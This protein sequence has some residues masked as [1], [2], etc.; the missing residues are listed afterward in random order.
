MSISQ[1]II[2]QYNKDGFVNIPSFYDLKTEILP[3]QKDIYQL[4][5]ILIKQHKLDIH[6]EPFSS[7]T[8]DSGLDV[9][10]EN[11]RPVV[12][13]IYDAVKKIPSYV[14]LACSP[15]NEE[16]A[17]VLLKTE[18]IGFANQGYGIR[19]DN[20]FEDAY[21]TQWHQDYVS[22]LCAK[23]GI[24]FWSP[25]RDVTLNMGPIE[26]RFGSHKDGIFRILRDGEGSYGLKI[27]DEDNIVKR[28]PSVAPEVKVG[29]LVAS[30]FLVL[31][32]S[33]PNR[34]KF[35]RWSMISRYFDFLDPE[36]I[37]YGW[38]GG[39]QDGNSFEKV[40][41]ELSEIITSSS[42]Q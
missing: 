17:R 8:F 34:S 21:R 20:P 23:N 29:D 25:L 19:M 3:I 41:P 27:K 33:S 31:H 40:H 1:K 38:K 14:K 2:D 7:L 35:T 28:Y 32:R 18:F 22:Q 24:V 37:A 36:G 42:Q 30:N 11:H 4:I 12:S 10:L 16:V 39:L 9:L 15:K 13:Q 6:Q 5:S 26:Y